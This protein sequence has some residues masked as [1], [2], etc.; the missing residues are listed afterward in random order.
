LQDGRPSLEKM[1][2]SLEKHEDA[3]GVRNFARTGADSRGNISR[4]IIN[5]RLHM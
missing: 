4:K 3:L 2:S 5:W 1:N